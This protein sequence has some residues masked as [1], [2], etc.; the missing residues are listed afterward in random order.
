M[1]QTM[2]VIQFVGSGVTGPRPLAPLWQLC[3]ALGIAI[4]LAACGQVSP[5]AATRPAATPRPASAAATLQPFPNTSAVTPAPS[6]TPL[7]L[8]SAF[9]VLAVRSAIQLH[10]ARSRSVALLVGST[11]LLCGGLT[12]AGTTGSIERIDLRSGRV[13]AG[14]ALS[15]PVHDAGGAVI[16]GYGFVF[17]GGRVGPGSV[18]QRIDPT[19]RTV[20]IGNLPAIR[21][22]L[23]AIALGSEIVVVGGGTPGHPDARVLA[24]TRGQT[25]RVV[26]KLVVAV[27][28]PAVVGVGGWVYVI[29][30]STAS[31]DTRIIQ[32]VDPRTGVVR[33]VGHLVHGLSHASAFVIGGAVILAGGRAAGRPQNGIWRLDAASGTVTPIGRMPYAVSDA[34]AAVFDGIGYLIGGEGRGPIASVITITAR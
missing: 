31:G 3:G 27:R 1:Q 21:A 7:A 13:S 25:F 29:G 22:D 8:A 23:A 24:T 20:R 14:G 16:G 6:P 28:Y 19:G 26:A 30:G 9:R 33:I 5:P 2:G 34:A 32:A 18:V 4:M 12:S 11:V 15:N 17:G 10:G